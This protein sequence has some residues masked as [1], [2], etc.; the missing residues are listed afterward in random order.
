VES[1]LVERET[2]FSQLFLLMAVSE[3]GKVIPAAMA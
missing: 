1:V 3:G 2:N